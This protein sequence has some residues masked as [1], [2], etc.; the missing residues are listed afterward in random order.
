MSKSTNSED[1]VERLRVLKEKKIELESLLQ[2]IETT[3]I[4]V[5]Q[6][7]YSFG[8]CGFTL[9]VLGWLLRATS[10]GSSSAIDWYSNER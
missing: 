8:Q 7:F 6:L 1:P 9:V 5:M 2:S 4:D 10:K 3:L